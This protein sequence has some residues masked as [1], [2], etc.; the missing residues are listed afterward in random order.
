MYIIF[1]YYSEKCA[2][3]YSVPKNVHNTPEINE[4]ALNFMLL[5]VK[6]LAR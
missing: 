3:L 1:F 4:S 6:A 2:A 5:I